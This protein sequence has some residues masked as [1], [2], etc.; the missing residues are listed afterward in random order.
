L[1]PVKD[2]ARAKSFYGALLGVEL[3][4]DSAYCVGFRVGEQELGLEP[5]DHTARLTACSPTGT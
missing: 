1:H 4:A 2:V 5:N 3:Y